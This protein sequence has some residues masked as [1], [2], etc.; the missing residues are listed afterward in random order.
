LAK[1]LKAFLIWV[2]IGIKPKKKFA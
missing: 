2:S 1:V